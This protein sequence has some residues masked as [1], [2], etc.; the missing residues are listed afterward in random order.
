MSVTALRLK[1]PKLAWPDYFNPFLLYSNS[2][3]KSFRPKLRFS[4]RSGPFTVKTAQTSDELAEILKLRHQIFIE[5]GLGY[6]KTSQLDFDKFDLQADH[7]LLID[8]ATH[9]VV[10][11]YRIL[12]SDWVKSFYSSQEFVTDRYLEVMR[13]LKLELG[14]ACIKKEYRK[15][16][17][18]H[19]VWKGL[20]RYIN[21]TS[22]DYLFGCTSVDSQSYS[23]VQ[24]LLGV[25]GESYQ[26]QIFDVKPRFRFRFYPEQSGIKL[27]QDPSELIPPL[28]GSY[29]K[30]GAQVFGEPA[31]DR[32]F[33]CFDLFTS[34]HIKSMNPKYKKK[35]IQTETE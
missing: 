24:D 20:G 22:A 16:T 26:S 21:L 13:G 5:E 7:I 35:Y 12:S 31:Y 11:T 25:L 17:A 1:N 14:R 10:G 18:I 27:Y 30:A 6:S 15:G 3:I 4:F 9:T 28:L 33:K 19:L 34:M 2:K 8:N 29:I 32:D 23:D